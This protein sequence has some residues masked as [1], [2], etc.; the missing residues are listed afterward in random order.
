MENALAAARARACASGRAAKP[1]MP[2][3]VLAAF[4][5]IDALAR[6]WRALGGR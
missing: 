1:K 5:R 6:R 3:S 4:G 2:V